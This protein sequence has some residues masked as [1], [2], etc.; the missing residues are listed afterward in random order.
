MDITERRRTEEAVA[1]ERNR[2]ARELHDS[3]TQDLFTAAMIARSLPQL[4]ESHPDRL[5]EGLD[6]LVRL[7]GGAQAEMRG[8]LLELRPEALLR[9][10]LGEL[11]EQL[12]AAA[13][14][15]S[16]IDVTTSVS[17]VS[18]LPPPAH[19]T[20]YRIAQEAVSNIVKHAA[21]RHAYIGLYHV[22]GVVDLVVRDDGCGFTVPE[23]AAEG[24]G[25]RSMRERADSIGGQ[26]ALT[27]APGEGTEVR[28]S[29]RQ[30]GEDGVEY[31][32]ED[33]NGES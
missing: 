28:L 27:S 6:D 31:N 3:V 30:P 12:A 26:L 11:V 33:G 14:G 7:T 24:F 25:L 18:V 4:A 23:S 5:R 1:E 16:R 19:L 20:V 22:D 21:A 13:C 32:G 17:G 9:R 15:R 8:L 10:P 2:L 29:W